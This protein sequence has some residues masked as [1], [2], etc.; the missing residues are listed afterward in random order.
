MAITK[1]IMMNMKY[2]F[3]ISLATLFVAVSLTACSDDEEYTVSGDGELTPMSIKVQMS[4]VPLQTRAV[5]KKFEKS[6]VLL[7]YFEHINGSEPVSV[8]MS[9]SLVSFK[10]N[11]LTDPDMSTVD[12]NTEETEDM[13]VTSVM[14][15]GVDLLPS[16]HTTL[17]WDD[18]SSSTYPIDKT[19]HALR[20]KYG[21]CYNGGTPSVALTPTTGKLG[22]TVAKDQTEGIK[23]YDLLWCT[24]TAGVSYVHDKDQ[25]QNMGIKIPYHHAMSKITLV[26]TAN[27]GFET[28]DPFASTTAS[29]LDMYRSCTVNAAAAKD[30]RITSPSKGTENVGVVDMHQKAKTTAVGDTKATCTFEALVVPTTVL[31]L[32][33]TIAQI[34][35]VENNTYNVTATQDVLNAFAE[36]TSDDSSVSL[37][38]GYNY[39]INVTIDKQGQTIVAQIADWNNVTATATG[40]IKFAADITSHDKDNQINTNGASIALWR[41]ATVAEFTGARTTTATFDNDDD[42]DET[43]DTW[44]CDPTLYWPDGIT[45]YHF[46]ALAKYDGATTTK[47]EAFSGEGGVDNDFK[48]KQGSDIVWATTAAHKGTYKEADG[49]TKTKEYDEGDP[50]NPR[51][52]TVPMAFEHAMSKITVKLETTSGAD[53]VALA[54]ATISIANIYDGGTIALEDGSI[55]TLSASTTIPISGLYAANDESTPKL[56]EYVVVPQSLKTMDGGGD[57]TGTV[58]FYNKSELTTMTVEGVEKTYVTSSLERINYTAADANELNELNAGLPGAIST[59][60]E[61]TPA[62]KYETQEEVNE[63]NATLDGA[64]KAGDPIYYIYAEFKALTNAQ[65]SEA[66]FALLTDAQ[67]THTYT[68]VDDYY[69]LT[70]NTISNDVFDS[71]EDT[72][73]TIVCTFEQYKKITPAFTPFGSYTDS[74][75]NNL[76]NP[77]KQKGSYTEDTANA[78]NAG[79]DGAVELND[80][81]SP[82]VYYTEA[83]VNAYNATLEGAK[84]AGDLKEY[85][86]LSTSKEAHPGDIKDDTVANPKI[87]MLITLADGTTYTLDLASCTDANGDEVDEW[88]RGEH[89]TYTIKLTKSDITFRALVKDWVEK[90]TSGNATLEWD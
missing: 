49:T 26:I 13:I 25:R 45:P 34:I 1:K 56:S 68:S 52:G 38:P 82:A 55:G 3:P 83:E 71:M 7:A 78:F 69:A 2:C 72:Q 57:R 22:W 60:D 77:K 50:I 27:L 44:V 75:F 10:M 79:L 48:V 76:E 11:E 67:K 84:K 33:N 8:G 5:D 80:E 58:A 9:P 85:N 14:Q 31:S 59:S 42:G 46:R 36:S 17:Y 20:V 61:K 65:I 90:S 37:K 81:K 19:G 43:E 66:M 63:K 54:G 23:A 24:G 29:L 74:D 73:K 86:V 18:F 88:K 89:Y 21:Y 70:G 30:S 40:E 32:N 41:K 6:D 12:S 51:T 87:M 16:G 15:D 47:Y 39:L 28:E 64:V 53:A 4:D 62:I 35:N